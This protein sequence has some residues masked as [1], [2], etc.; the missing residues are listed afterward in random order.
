[1][2]EKLY[3][4]GKVRYKKEGTLIRN[5]K[6]TSDEKIEQLQSDNNILLMSIADIYSELQNLKGDN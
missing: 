4:N 3:K 1:M 5:P 2:N 6:E